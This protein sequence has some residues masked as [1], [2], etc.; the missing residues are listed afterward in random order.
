MKLIKL[1]TH[2]GKKNANQSKALKLIGEFFPDL[3]KELHIRPSM[4][5]T[6]IYDKINKKYKLNSSLKGSLY[7][8][9]MM[10][11][12][13][14]KKIKPFFYQA[15]LNFV[16]NVC[17]DFV[18]F[19]TNKKPIIISIKTSGRELYKQVELESFVAKQVHK[20][21]R[22][23]FIT[24]EDDSVRFIDRKKDLSEINSIDE[25]YSSQDKDFDKLI[26]DLA[27]R[28]YVD[29]QKISYVKTGV[30]IDD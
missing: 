23:I 13:F 9:L 5:I 21:A 1:F 29:P 26:N 30:L 25:V 17:F 14:R 28:D 18:L 6:N 20:N 4:F 12:F 3:D 10:C 16:P 22:T 27:S 15:N 7:E 19:D 11:V 24:H 2:K 8:H